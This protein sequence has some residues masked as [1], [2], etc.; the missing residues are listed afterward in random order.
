MSGPARAAAAQ[1]SYP[2]K[3]IRIV[4]GFSAG[5]GTDAIA[6]ALARQMASDL[7]TNVFIDNKPGAN[8]NIA[9][10]EVSR[11][12]ADGYTLLY[13]TSA[14]ASSPALYSKRLSYDVTKNLTPVALTASLPIVLV[15]PTNSPFKT[16][17]ELVAYAKANPGKLNY[18]S[19]GNGNVTH[20]SS[21]LFE[22][23]VGIKCTHVPYKGEAP[24]IVDLMAGMVDYYFAT[25]A[26]AIPAVK[27]GRLK[28]LAV[29]TK[30]PLAS[31]PGVPTLDATV[32]KNLELAAWSGL[33]APAGTPAEIIARLNASVNK[34]LADPQTQRFF[35]EQGA[36]ATPSTPEQY[37]S[38]LRKEI[39]SLAKV[40]KAS[41]L[42]LD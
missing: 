4:L 5:G 12:P 23:A 22:D 9:A 28:A 1:D 25:S 16:V 40:I 3:P 20:L 42:T 39:D 14:I 41:G 34:A 7:H 31:L 26:G 2:S 24:A 30:Q 27:S 15:V 33:M 37:Q 11:A 10:D 32:A 29:A 13:N 18:A 19:A 36:Q 17:Q 35:A 21:L 6:R 38:F 8:G